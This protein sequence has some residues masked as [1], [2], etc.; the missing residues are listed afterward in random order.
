MKKAFCRE[1]AFGL[2]LFIFLFS[3]F[4]VRAT[5]TCEVPTSGDT[6]NATLPFDFM[7]YS[8]L[9]NK[10]RKVFA[11]YFTPFP[12][13]LDNKYWE[14]DYY[15]RNYLSP[16]GENSKFL[17]R[18][19][20]L[21]AR[22]LPRPVN[23]S[24]NWELQDMRKEVRLAKAVGIDGFAVDILNYEGVHWKRTK[25]MLE[26]AR[27][28][29][30][31]F[32]IV[33][34]PDMSAA[35]SRNPDQFVPMIRELAK[36]PAAMRVNGK[37]VVAPYNAQ[38]QTAQWWRN[39]LNR[40]RQ[41][42]ID[43]A[44]VPVFQGWKKYVSQYADFS[45]GISD[46]GWRNPSNS[47]TNYW[48][49]M[50]DIA[51]A[52]GLSWMHPVAPQDTRPKSSTYWEAANSR[53]YRQNWESAIRGGADWV[54]LVTWNDYS[55]H[56][57]ITPSTAG[58]GYYDLT[59]YYVQW[60]KTGQRPRITH[61]AI[62]GFNRSHTLGARPNPLYQT[63]SMIPAAGSVAPENQ[64]EMLAFLTE[65]ATLEIELAGKVHRRDFGRGIYS[66]TIPAEPGTPT[67]RIKRNGVV[68]E[69]V[70]GKPIQKYIK[71][72]DMQYHSVS[73]MR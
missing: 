11:H 12:V 25:L 53:L 9:V 54:Q 20:Y 64:V 68:V 71:V 37:L 17:S 6:S 66:F 49:G 23:D 10:K 50:A 41:L 67:F 56:S 69:S 14:N 1:S 62:Y 36:H 60:Y 18:G 46:W 28:E 73:S 22:P 24:A 55:E 61:D 3:S 29:G 30:G 44:F 19:G 27:I 31:G 47:A 72:Q 48:M 39:K 65:P 21:R 8:E 51:H 16:D 40:L 45:Y 59:A 42:G 43:V 52:A 32:K 26:A 35:L 34:M 38:K 57:G 5:T 7:T 63:I 13:S 4:S 2:L 70:K 33:L 58:Y 15:T